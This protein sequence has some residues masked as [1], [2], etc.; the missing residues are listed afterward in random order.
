MD[1]GG[2]EPNG[3]F[4]DA[5]YSFDAEPGPHPLSILGTCL[6]PFTLICA[7]FTIQE[8]SQAVQLHCGKYTGTKR[9]PGLSASLCCGR[10]LRK[11]STKK[12]VME[13]PPSNIVDSSGSPLRVGVVFTF[14][15]ENCVRA[16]LAVDNPIELLRSQA[17]AV[18][19]AIVSKYPYELP[20]GHPPG[21]HC[22]K[23]EPAFVSREAIAMLQQ[24][25]DI[26]GARILSF[27]LNELSYAP[28]IAAALLKRQAAE[29]V[30]DARQLLVRGGVQIVDHAV[31]DLA[32][33][34]VEMNEHE[35]ARLI[36]GLLSVVIAD[37]N[38]D[39]H[40]N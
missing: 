21:A 20:K 16:A 2:D 27:S 12:Q 30:I 29:A 7:P 14:V 4:D 22:L 38:H 23:D 13:L 33:A 9:E 3:G 19:R 25:V 18:T 24:K 6:C 15:F 36:G 28:E 39:H 8:Q 10:E 34:G 37:K 40:R 5:A 26:A 17:T 1:D 31:R 11:I 35:K 32:K